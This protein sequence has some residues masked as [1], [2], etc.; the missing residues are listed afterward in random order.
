MNDLALIKTGF[1]TFPLL[2]QIALNEKLWKVETRRQITPGSPHVD[3]ESIILR[4]CRSLEVEAVFT[5][6]ESVDFP[7]LD[8]LPHARQLIDSILKELGASHS[9]LGRAMIVSLK[10]GGHI[11]AH[12][13]EGAYADT[14]ERF[15]L[16]LF[17][18]VGN[19][20]Y[21]DKEYAHM[22]SGEL[23]WF[24]H[25]KLHTAANRSAGDR[26]HLIVDI[27]SPKYRRE[28]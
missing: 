13:D 10:A 3:T 9:D 23:W 5:E 19:V 12:V 16:P 6:I 15:H 22:K 2:E 26:W 25:K 24:N 7:S 8:A 27:K 4:W 28:R 1:N 11:R 18:D 14:Y 21:V 20:F 17:S